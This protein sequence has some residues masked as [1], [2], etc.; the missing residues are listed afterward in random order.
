M[1]ARDIG[2]GL[3]QAY[4]KTILRYDPES[5]LLYW[6]KPNTSENFTARVEL[7]IRFASFINRWNREKSA[8]IP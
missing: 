4:L 6:V 1:R 2:S 7:H 8:S 5:G 3:T